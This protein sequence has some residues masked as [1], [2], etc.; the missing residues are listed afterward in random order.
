MDFAFTDTQGK[1]RIKKKAEKWP[2]SPDLAWAML[3]NECL[4]PICL[5]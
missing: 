4:S 5:I 1:V 2:E 3:I